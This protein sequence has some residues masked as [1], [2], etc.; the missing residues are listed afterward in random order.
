MIEHH[1]GVMLT[2]PDLPDLNSLKHMVNDA[3][4]DLEDV[5]NAIDHAVE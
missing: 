5:L 1:L 2:S 3:S 4:D